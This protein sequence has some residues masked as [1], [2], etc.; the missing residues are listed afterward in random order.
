MH[1]KH[2]P[3]HIFHRADGLY[4]QINCMQVLTSL[5]AA[6]KWRKSELFFF[7]SSWFIHLYTLQMC[8]SET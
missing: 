5:A 2:S 4:S 6:V 1:V 8:V 3:I 7:F